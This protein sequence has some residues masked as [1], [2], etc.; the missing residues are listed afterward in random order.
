MHTIRDKI[1]IRTV[2]SDADRKTLGQVVAVLGPLVR[3]NPLGRYRAMTAN[4]MWLTLVIQVCVMGSARHM[5]RIEADE[6]KRADFE[7]AVSRQMMNRPDPLPYLAETLRSFSAT[8]FPQRSAE[9]LLS[10]LL[11]PSVFHGEEIVLLEGLSHEDDAIQ[12]R[13]TLVARCPIFRLKSASDFMIS[14]GLSRDVIALDTRIVG[15]LNQHFGYN[16]TAD[17][18]QSHRGRYISLEAALREF[19][20]GVG[21]SLAL[22]DRLLFRFANLGAIEL[23][24]KHPELLCSPASSNP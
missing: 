3:I 5:E 12:T 19:C 21:F 13:D 9:R 1:G 22:L 10:V 16:L 15:I 24:V 14:V 2:L 6:M 17:Q 7:K 23:I 20:R 18:I 4:D 11:S 8:R